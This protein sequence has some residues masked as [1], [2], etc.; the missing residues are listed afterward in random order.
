MKQVVIFTTTNKFLDRL[1]WW[2]WIKGDS[3]K[4]SG[5]ESFSKNFQN[6]TDWKE[7][8]LLLREPVKRHSSKDMFLS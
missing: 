1:R 7:V 2:R 5:N 6:T 8:M 4:K 3:K